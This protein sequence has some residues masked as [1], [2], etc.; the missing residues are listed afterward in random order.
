MGRLAPRRPI[1]GL[2]TPGRIERIVNALFPTHL[3]RPRGVWSREEPVI[4]VTDAEVLETAKQILGNKTPGLDGIPGEAL[5]LLAKARS[6]RLARIFNLCLEQGK[7][8]MAWKRTGLVLPRK[9]NR[10]LEEPSSYRSLC[11]LDV[12][13]KFFEKIVDTPL[14]TVSEENAMFTDN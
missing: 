11:M 13:G 5:K 6:A 7:F 12:A 8:P 1:P 3:G 9:N 4:P 2:N 14:K 10:P